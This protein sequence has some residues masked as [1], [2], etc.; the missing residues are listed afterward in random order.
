MGVS[1]KIIPY[2]K[3]KKNA[4]DKIEVLDFLVYFVDGMADRRYNTY[5][6]RGIGD[7][8]TRESQY[9]LT[10]RVMR[11]KLMDGSGQYVNTYAFITG[12]AHWFSLSKKAISTRR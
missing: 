2:K 11:G 6:S 10:G 8:Y 9:G 7:L 12:F 1:A 5:Y 4:F 3:D